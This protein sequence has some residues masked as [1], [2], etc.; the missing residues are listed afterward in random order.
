MGAV[1]AGWGAGYFMAIVSTM[2][3][4]YLLTKFDTRALFSSVIDPGVPRALIA[5]PYFVAATLTWSFIGLS[6]GSIYEVAG[7][8]DG[9]GGLGSPHLG[10]TLG[11]CALAA[12]PVPVL[13][14][15]AWRLWWVWLLMSAIFA[16]TF[17]WAMPLLETRW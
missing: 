9:P 13:T 6:L 10:F 11:I 1:I 2:A 7:F 5:V 4:A 15:V 3:V 12:M 16:A 14:A 8:A 17:G